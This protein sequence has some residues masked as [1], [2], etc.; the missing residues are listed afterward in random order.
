MSF[1][2]YYIHPY[3][4]DHCFGLQ[5]S[6][7][8]T[9]GK[10]GKSRLVLVCEF[11]KFHSS[12]SFSLRL[13]FVR[14]LETSLSR[15]KNKTFVRWRTALLCVRCCEKNDGLRLVVGEGKAFLIPCCDFSSIFLLRIK[16]FLSDFRNSL[17]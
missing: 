6:Y 2:V 17:A 15:H 14:G 13:S 3:R 12:S 16:Y 7:H 5:K 11:E 9:Q 10:D 8:Q 4:S 1:R